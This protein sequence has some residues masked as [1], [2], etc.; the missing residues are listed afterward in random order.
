MKF[1]V[2][3]KIRILKDNLA[4]SGWMPG[5]VA[6]VVRVDHGCIWAQRFPRDTR[7][8]FNE[9][10]FEHIELVED[11]DVPTAY[12]SESG[13][14]YPSEWIDAKDLVEGVEYEC[15]YGMKYNFRLIEDTLEY[16]HAHNGWL[17]VIGDFNDSRVHAIYTK[18]KF[19][20]IEKEEIRELVIYHDR[21]V[22]I[23]ASCHP[24]N[25]HDDIDY[26]QLIT[27]LKFKKTNG[28]WEV[29]Q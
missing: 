26:R 18:A 24:F 10:R 17:K 20:K 27:K 23:I 3:D 11:S 19:R 14:S 13:I 1:K 12:M 8:A 21:N 2:G 25:W 6:D 9:T 28:K 5:D 15:D 29:A 4:D 16:H 7:M 22:D